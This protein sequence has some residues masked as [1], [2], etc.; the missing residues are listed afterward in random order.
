MEATL[1]SMVRVCKRETA[2]LPPTAFRYW[3]IIFCASS[4]RAGTP[5][6]VVRIRENAM[7]MDL[8][9]AIHYPLLDTPNYPKSCGAGGNFFSIPGIASAGGL[10]TAQILFVQ[11]LLFVVRGCELALD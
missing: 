6:K 11:G 2:L 10:G 5:N 9:M 1:P 8:R 4:A 7:N 3:S